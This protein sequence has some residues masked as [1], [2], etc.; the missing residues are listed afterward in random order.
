MSASTM[1]AGRCSGEY[2]AL[3]RA[4]VRPSASAHLLVAIAG[5]DSLPD[6][7]RVEPILATRLVE[8]EG[9]DRRSTPGLFPTPHNGH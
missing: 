6:T 5:N 4:G 9:G 7:E 3:P 1:A 8:E 2:S